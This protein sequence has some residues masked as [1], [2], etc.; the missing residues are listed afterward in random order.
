MKSKMKRWLSLVL[1]MVLLCGTVPVAFAAETET[2]LYEQLGFESADAL[3]EGW[4]FGP[5]DYD[6]V[7]ERYEVYLAELTANPDKAFE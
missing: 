5:V 2:P 7:C 3:M 4:I 6:W 1:A